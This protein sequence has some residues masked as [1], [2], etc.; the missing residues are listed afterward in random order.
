MNDQIPNQDPVIQQ[1]SEPVVTPPIPTPEIE[2][3]PEPAST[4]NNYQQVLNQYAANTEKIPPIETPQSTEEQLKDLGIATPPKTGGGFFKGL[5]VI[6]LII[7]VF[8]MVTLG[9]VFFK[10]QKNTNNSDSNFDTVEPTPTNSD[11]QNG[12]CFLNDRNYQIGESF[13]LADGCNTC[14]C[15]SADVITCTE[16]DCLTITPVSTLSANKTTP[17]ATAN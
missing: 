16:K 1:P 10:S 11:L 17:S 7:F 9:L 5:F 15:E 2:S 13:A 8:V 12:A 4:S 3:T 14:T 6:A